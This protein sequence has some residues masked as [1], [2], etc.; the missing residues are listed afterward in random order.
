MQPVISTP[1]TLLNNKIYPMAFDEQI[2]WTDSSYLFV[3]YL[4]GDMVNNM[5]VTD[6]TVIFDVIVAKKL[7][8]IQESDGTPA[9]RP[10]S[11]MRE[12]VSQF[13]NQSVGSVGKLIFKGFR[14]IGVDQTFNAMRLSAKMTGFSGGSR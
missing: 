6:T 3:Y 7:W 1:S 11:I 2:E 10:Y 9:I 8:R 13:R 4:V 12:I 14:Q 5:V